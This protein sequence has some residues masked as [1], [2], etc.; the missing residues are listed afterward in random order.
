[1][2]HTNHLAHTRQQPPRVRAVTIEWTSHDGLRPLTASAA[3][4]VLAAAVMARLGIPPLPIMWPMYQLG[5]VAPTCGLTRGVVALARTEFA[6]A[7]RWNPASYPI[8]LSAVAVAIRFGIGVL[9]KRWLHLRLRPTW[10]LTT[11]AGVLLVTL[12]LRQQANADL[13]MSAA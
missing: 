6:D 3:A 8:G 12:W 11:I 13:L 10:R 2:T 1:M 7:W 4:I 9:T 5:L